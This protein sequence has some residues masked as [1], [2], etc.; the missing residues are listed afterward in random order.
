MKFYFKNYIFIFSKRFLGL[1]HGMA[2]LGG[3]S[4]GSILLPFSLTLLPSVLRKGNESARRIAEVKTFLNQEKGQN[5]WLVALWR[6]WLLDLEGWAQY[7]KPQIPQIG[8][9]LWKHLKGCWGVKSVNTEMILLLPWESA[10]TSEKRECL[11]RKYN[12]S[13]D[14]EDRK[15]LFKTSLFLF[16]FDW[17]LT[18]VQN[19]TF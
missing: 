8:F 18:K 19:Y 15:Y 2:W 3:F 5:M 13:F 7:I 12:I 1:S 6:R 4:R 10:K 16:V 11:K 14:V 9:T 17:S